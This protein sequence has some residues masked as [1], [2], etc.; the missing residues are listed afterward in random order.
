MGSL[1]LEFADRAEKQLDEILSYIAIDNPDAA[2]KVAD[3][4]V[5]VL[6]KVREF[7]KM[8]K[9]AFPKLPYREVQAYPCR[10][11]Y[12]RLKDLILVV[13][14][15]RGEQLRRRSMLIQ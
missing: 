8:G 7:P 1:K 13:A 4:V 6:E 3:E 11:F 5:A 9:E 2:A 14:V 10:I 12:R 15:I